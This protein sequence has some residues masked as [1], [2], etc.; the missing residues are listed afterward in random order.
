M[1]G[2]IY[3]YINW[4]KNS[5]A[6]DLIQMEDKL[7]KQDIINDEDTEIIIKTKEESERAL[8]E[9]G[10]Q[11]YNIIMQLKA[12]GLV[13]NIIAEQNCCSYIKNVDYEKIISFNIN[14][15]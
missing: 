15:L 14:M 6:H 1:A 11:A 5:C 3:N 4:Q 2:R 12:Y 8:W 13:P 10:Y 9:L 7:I